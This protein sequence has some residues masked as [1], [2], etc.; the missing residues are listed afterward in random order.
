MT[1]TEP[2]LKSQGMRAHDGPYVALWEFSFSFLEQSVG[3]KVTG[4]YRTLDTVAGNGSVVC[5][6]WFENASRIKSV[7]VQIINKTQY[8]N[9]DM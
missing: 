4:L 5:L 1:P 6:G 9:N 3:M 7:T 8:T 2:K